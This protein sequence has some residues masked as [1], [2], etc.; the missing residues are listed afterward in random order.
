VHHHAW[1]MTPVTV[2]MLPADLVV[3]GASA[4][5]MFRVRIYPQQTV[6][7]F[8]PE[9]LN[10][11][12]SGPAQISTPPSRSSQCHEPRSHPSLVC[13]GPSHARGTTRTSRAHDGCRPARA[14]P[15]GA[16]HR[17]AGSPGRLRYYAPLAG[18][19]S[20]TG[21]RSRGAIDG[22]TSPCGIRSS[23][24]LGSDDAAAGTSVPPLDFPGRCPRSWGFAPAVE[25]GTVGLLSLRPQAGGAVLGA[26]LSAARRPPV[27]RDTAW[28]GIHSHMPLKKVASYVYAMKKFPNTCMPRTRSLLTYM[29]FWMDG[30]LTKVLES[31]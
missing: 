6:S 11:I 3:I 23:S 15:S 20:R 22:A 16:G 26:R 13:R 17:R 28:Y 21:T 2:S 19:W 30:E 27:H 7:R 31:V 10:Q 1:H 24:A 8:Q 4:T 12:G 18:S 5:Y 29:L 9:V 25:H 14:A